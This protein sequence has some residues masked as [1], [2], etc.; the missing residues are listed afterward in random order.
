M[1]AASVA[2]A[3]PAPGAG[4]GTVPAVSGTASVPAG[5]P[6]AVVGDNLPPY[7]TVITPRLV[8]SAFKVAPGLAVTAAHVVEG[9]PPGARV[10]L[11][12]GPSGGPTVSA[13]LVGL[14][15]TMDLAVLEVP[16]GFLPAIGLGTVG[17][18]EAA[19]PVRPATPAAGTRLVASGSVPARDPLVAV[20]R[21]VSGTASGRSVDVAGL[22]PGFVASLPG[23]VPGFSGGPV[24]DASGRL[25]GM[26]IAIRRLPA[27]GRHDGPP[28][29]TALS[30]DVYV[31]AAEPLVAE[32]RRL[33]A[34]S[35]A[36]L[37][38]GR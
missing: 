23:T 18:G 12:R 35:S 34:R 33:A 28:G 27:A 37:S 16:A 4:A 20:P 13:R 31:L 22:G 15:P 1:A 29:R 17:R 38:T 25:A 3:S 30:D 6:S 14:S 9:L 26:V 21:R 11:R 2:A 19:G 7:A 5:A 8:G 10:T 24:I 32:A 36:P